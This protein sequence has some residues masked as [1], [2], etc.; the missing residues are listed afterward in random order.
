MICDLENSLINRLREIGKREIE[1][2][3][4]NFS[5]AFL[6]EYAINKDPD[7]EFSIAGIIE[8][9]G[10][11]HLYY[12]VNREQFYFDVMID[13]EKMNVDQ[14]FVENKTVCRLSALAPDSEHWYFT[15]SFPSAVDRYIHE[16]RD[17]RLELHP[18]K[19]FIYDVE[20]QIDLLLS[21]IEGDREKLEEL[22]HWYNMFIEVDIYQHV[23][24]RNQIYLDK[25]LLSRIQHSIFD[26]SIDIHQC[27][28]TL[29]YTEE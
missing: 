24:T 10:L 28:K 7:G 27:G 8:K 3:K 23:M 4:M 12:I 9:G 2:P 19:R 18:K 22:S 29:E 6:N 26:L 14:T 1:K 21:P 11:Y 15:R 25:T 16:R 13:N 5:A 17:N 20:D